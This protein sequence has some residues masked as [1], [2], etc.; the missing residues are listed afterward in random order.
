MIFFTYFSLKHNA[1]LFDKFK[2]SGCK[3]NNKKKLKQ[4]KIQKL[5]LSYFSTH[6]IVA[7]KLMR[8]HVSATNNKYIFS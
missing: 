5:P 3:N 8:I 1:S 2:E 6:V 7:K 4:K